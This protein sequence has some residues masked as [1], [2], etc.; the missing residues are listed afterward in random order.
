MVTWFKHRDKAEKS[1]AKLECGLTLEEARK[2]S[3]E[4]FNA[5]LAESRAR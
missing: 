4:S 2:K 1:D 5:A 3:Q